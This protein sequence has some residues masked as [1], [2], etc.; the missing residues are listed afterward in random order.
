MYHIT[1][2]RQQYKGAFVNRLLKLTI[3][4]TLM[5]TQVILESREKKF[6]EFLITVTS[7]NIKRSLLAFLLRL[8][9]C[10]HD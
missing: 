3:K 7:E 5:Y 10:S 2:F 4:M 9:V 1:V 8:N 6:E